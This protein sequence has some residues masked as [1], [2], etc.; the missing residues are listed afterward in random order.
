MHNLNSACA[1]RLSQDSYKTENLNHYNRDSPTSNDLGRLAVLEDPVL[2]RHDV[3]LSDAELL[4]E[5]LAAQLRVLHGILHEELLAGARGAGDV[6]VA[7]RR[8]REHPADG[9]ERIL[10]AVPVPDRALMVGCSEVRRHLVVVPPELPEDHVG[11][12]HVLEGLLHLI[13]RQ[14]RAR[15]HLGPGR[16]LRALA[17]AELQHASLHGLADD[18]LD[19][20][21]GRQ[22]L[23]AEGAG[24][25]RVRDEGGHAVPRARGHH[26]VA[27]GAD[28][29][30]LGCIGEIRGEPLR[31][32]RSAAIGGD[33]GT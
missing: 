24:R 22:G 26:G 32:E 16:R 23:A 27:F 28:R 8:Q 1:P 2:A 20:V 5:L 3:D 30:V 7:V 31:A 17:R 18:G 29:E 10:L 21:L 19:A 12:S 15:R 13:L 25:R 6:A 9:G 14:V 4:R 33:V 11:R